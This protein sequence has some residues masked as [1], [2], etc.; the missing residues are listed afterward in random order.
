MNRAIVRVWW[1][2]STEKDQQQQRAVSFRNQLA[3]S[4]GAGHGSVE[5]QQ[6]GHSE[7][8]TWGAQQQN[9]SFLRGVSH[10]LS[11]SSIGVSGTRPTYQSD[12]LAYSKDGRTPRREDWAY[13]LP[14]RDTKKASECGL[15]GNAMIDWW[16]QFLADGHNY[17]V[18]SK[19]QN[20]DAVTVGALVAGG[21][22]CYAP[23]P[24]N[25][26]YQGA[27]TLIQWVPKVDEG[28]TTWNNN[29]SVARQLLTTPELTKRNMY[30]LSTSGVSQIPT[31]RQWKRIS[32]VS[33]GSR[34]EQIAKIDKYLQQYWEAD[35][36]SAWTK[37]AKKRLALLKILHQVYL[38]MTLKPRSRRHEAVRELGIVCL[39]VV[40]E[41]HDNMTR[42]YNDVHRSLAQSGSGAYEHVDRTFDLHL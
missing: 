25:L 3:I 22:D 11:A 33:F 14:L 21:A 23:P 34:K 19:T 39:R 37:E 28:I 15:D 12:K 42:L 20:C 27:Y 38:H 13:A 36:Q 41:T 1:L 9:Y 10:S 4:L 35:D 17:K 8:I 18:I 31:V 29:L 2:M 5:V 7:Y 16:E 24:W 26:L 6:N 40:T 32:S 30:L